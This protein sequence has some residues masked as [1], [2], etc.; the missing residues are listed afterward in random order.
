MLI[1]E[2]FIQGWQDV[3]P[4]VFMMVGVSGSGK[5]TVARHLG[6]AMNIPVV[7]TDSFIEQRAAEQGRSYN[8]IFADTIKDAAVAMASEIEQLVPNQSF[9]W[10]QTN[11][12]AKTR[13]RKLAVLPSGYRVVFVTISAPRDVVVQRLDSRLDKKI[14]K[15][16]RQDQSRQF[17]YVDLTLDGS[18]FHSAASFELPGTE[19]LDHLFGH[20]DSPQQII[21]RLVANSRYRNKSFQ[22]RVDYA[23]A[24]IVEI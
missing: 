13:S 24:H 6:A 1:F 14:S 2:E 10:D 20:C 22:V 23:V 21:E 11:L 3:R 15:T 18:G 12:S 19:N 9:V 5:S 16:I 4:T 7:S 8:D 17:E